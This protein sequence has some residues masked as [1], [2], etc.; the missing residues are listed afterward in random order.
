MFTMK[1]PQNTA[2]MALR[3]NQL[4]IPHSNHPLPS[5]LS[6]RI[7]GLRQTRPKGMY[8]D[9]NMGKGCNSCGKG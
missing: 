9:M 6:F 4:M 2:A 8:I 3:Q 1:Y 7:N 5:S